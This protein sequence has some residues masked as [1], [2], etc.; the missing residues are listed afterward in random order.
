VCIYSTWKSGGYNTI[1][2]TS[3]ASP[4]GAGL[5]ALYKIQNP[6]AAPAD[7]MSKLRADAASWDGANGFTGDP[8]SSPAAGRYY[9]YLAH[10]D[11]Y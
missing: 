6:T 1:S 7:V 9:G 2:G 4:H 11:G 8:D 5:A 3:M 10:A